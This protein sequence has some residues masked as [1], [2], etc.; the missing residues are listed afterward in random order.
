MS[1]EHFALIGGVAVMARMGQAHRSTQDIDTAVDQKGAI[2]SELDVVVDAATSA[3]KGRAGRVRIGS[4]EVG[5]TPA[6]D[7]NPED[8]PEEEFPAPSSS[9]IAGFPHSFGVDTPLRPTPRTRHNRDV[10]RGYTSGA[11]GHEAPAGTSTVTGQGPKGGEPTS[12]WEPIRGM[13]IRWPSP[14]NGS[15]VDSLNHAW[16]RFAPLH[17]QD[18]AVNSFELTVRSTLRR[19]FAIVAYRL[20]T[21]P[22]FVLLTWP[23]QA[24]VV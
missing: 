7:L 9:P 22:S 17:T 11:G 13:T 24:H 14:S 21:P 15:L 8:L 23:W 19:V 12:S 18:D 4:I 2:P 6:V 10:P 16:Q 3:E 1:P 20:P 5:G